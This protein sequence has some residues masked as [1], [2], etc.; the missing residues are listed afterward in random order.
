MWNPFFRSAKT[1]GDDATRLRPSNWNQ[2]VDFLTALLN[3]D[4]PP[5]D[6]Y[7]LS[8]D[9]ASDAGASWIQPPIVTVQTIG[10]HLLNSQIKALN[11]APYTLLDDP[12][13]GFAY[14]FLEARIVAN[15]A[16]AYNP[17][18]DNASLCVVTTDDTAGPLSTLLSNDDT[19]M[20]TPLTDLNVLLDPSNVP[21]T[22]T[23]LVPWQNTWKTS[24]D[25]VFKQTAGIHASS[26]LGKGM[27]L[28]LLMQTPAALTGGAGGNS[29][30][31]YL[32]YATYQLQ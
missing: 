27:A 5:P 10:F 16:V 6:G 17:I 21:F 3:P 2:V 11:A 13:E 28:K 25:G 30:D 18:V 22:S 14:E 31:V 8:K 19:V 29:M 12:P 23:V 15:L 32:T 9:S 4:S 7:L 26:E 20:P 1:D 24:D